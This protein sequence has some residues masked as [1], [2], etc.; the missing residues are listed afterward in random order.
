MSGLKIHFRGID[1]AAVLCGEAAAGDGFTHWVSDVNC[2][3]CQRRFPGYEPEAPE[4]GEGEPGSGPADGD[5][6]TGK[7]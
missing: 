5:E 4:E 7:G 6:N 3:K 2:G 1:D